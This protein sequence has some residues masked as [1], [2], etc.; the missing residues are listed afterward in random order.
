MKSVR[1][2]NSSAAPATRV[3]SGFRNLVRSKWPFLL[4]PALV[5]AA[6]A[7]LYIANRPGLQEKT[8]TDARAGKASTGSAVLAHRGA[9]ERTSSA[10]SD[11]NTSSAEKTAS[12]LP[13]GR[14]PDDEGRRPNT[15]LLPTSDTNSPVS[16]GIGPR[17]NEPPIIG[18]LRQAVQANDHAALKGHLDQLVAMG[19]QAIPALCD[20]IA[21]GGDAAAVWAAEALARIGTPAATQSL[22]NTFS[23]MS[24]GL[25]KEQIAKKLSCISNHD[26]WPILLD[27]V[28]TSSDAAVRRAA[29]TSLAQMADVPIVDELVA[30][31]DSAVTVD[32]ASDWA[33]TVSRIS[34]SK[35]TESLLALAQEVSV[36]SE[37]PLD[38]AVLTAIANV[39]DAQCVNY[40]LT[41]LE[42][43]EPGE[44]STLMNLIS[45][46]SQ[47]QAQ[48]A[49]LY[50]AAGNKNVSAEQG[51]TAAIQALVNYPNEQSY[52]LLEQI[53]SL[54]RNATVVTA[55]SRTLAAIQRA[56]PMLATSA[57]FRAGEHILV[58]NPVQK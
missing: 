5:V 46:I 42:S 13:R 1:D 50:A 31:Y 43:S 32:E 28:L 29:S 7:V 10:T 8:R 38:Q 2:S 33:N 18:L 14:R 6:L 56:A 49:L 47:P 22:L 48:A 4:Y 44:T 51:R 17:A 41:R 35:A 45:A 34:S 9:D 58:T 20:L 11:P 37:D 36:S 30:R 24:D 25:Y 55:A 16:A 15:R 52:V 57:Q 21:C 26:S 23:Q 3:S 12:S 54:E 19:D 53:V 27:A 39:G 40:L